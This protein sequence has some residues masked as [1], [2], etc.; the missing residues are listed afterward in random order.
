MVV[1]IAVLVLLLLILFI[2]PEALYVK[3]K[4]IIPRA[5]SYIEQEESE[6]RDDSTRDAQEKAQA[7]F[8]EIVA[9]YQLIADDPHDNC[10]YYLDRSLLSR[11]FRTTRVKDS[12]FSISFQDIGWGKTAVWLYRGVSTGESPVTHVTVEGF[13][14]C[15]VY[16]DLN[17]IAN[18]HDDV[19]NNDLMKLPL[20][21]PTRNYGNTY[22]RF[23]LDQWQ[24]KIVTTNYQ[25]NE[26]Q[27]TTEEWETRD[28]MDYVLFKYTNGGEKYICLFPTIS[29]RKCN[30]DTSVPPK[31]LSD[32]C[33]KDT[34]RGN[35]NL[36][37]AE[38]LY[39]FIKAGAQNICGATT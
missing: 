34:G 11:I 3:I 32:G 2:G 17:K 29:E 28:E 23:D 7:A 14:P 10:F 5:D 26:K 19:M 16:N 15:L 37:D 39:E 27:V 36:K 18:F 8:D 25:T 21:G 38:T 35:V 33:F 9:A 22:T 13:R 12:Y 6:T 30:M 24:V 20:G 1:A 31:M 4:S